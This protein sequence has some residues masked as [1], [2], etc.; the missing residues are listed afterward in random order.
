MATIPQIEGNEGTDFNDQHNKTVLDTLNLCID[1]VNS[2]TGEG[3][4][5]DERLD[6][7]EATAP[8]S[9]QKTWLNGNTGTNVTLTP[10]E[11]GYLPSSAEKTWLGA[12][13]SGVAVTSAQKTWLDGQATSGK[14]TVTTA[15]HAIL[16]ALQAGGNS[17]FVALGAPVVAD[18]D[19][20]VE[21]VQWG[22]GTLTIAAQPDVPRNVT[23]TLTD[24]DNSV[25]GL[26]TINGTD[27]AGRVIS[28]TMA[29][30]G[31][32]GGKT[33]TGTK[34]FKTITSVV[35]TGTAGA[36]AGDNLVVGVGNVI[37]VPVDLADDAEVVASHLGGTLLV[38]PTV[39]TGVSTSGI[40]ASASTYNGSKVLD[41]IIQMGL[42]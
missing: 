4:T 38:A 8:S 33:L 28:E 35:I 23:A 39:A 40:D 30:N 12:Q 6:A 21:S 25:S 3:G 42:T 24:A 37:G 19:R 13:S 20:V 29:P 7:L 26:L 22:D 32:G 27:I 36:G 10:T 34:V 9:A 1:K 15:E 5:G 31:A 41:A 2:L 11:K 14:Q 16:T 18:T 17:F